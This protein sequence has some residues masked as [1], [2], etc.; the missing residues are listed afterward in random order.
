MKHLTKAISWILVCLLLIGTM[1]AALLPAMVLTGA[2][3]NP[4]PDKNKDGT[5][6][7][8]ATVK[9]GTV[10]DGHTLNG[11][12][13][14]SEPYEIASLVDWNYFAA[15]AA[16]AATKDTHFKLT[17][18]IYMNE[19]LGN[20]DEGNLPTV[21][22]D[23]AGPIN[24]VQPTRYTQVPS[25]AGV[26]DG[27]GYALYNPFM[28]AEKTTALFGT[29]TGTV[30]NL[31]VYGGYLVTTAGVSCSTFVCTLNGGTLRNC[32]VTT[33][34][35]VTGGGSGARFGGI[36]AVTDATSTISECV[37]TGTVVINSGSDGIAGGIVG[38]ANSGAL[39]IED[40]VN[41]GN[42]ISG[43]SRT[44][45]FVG[46]IVSGTVDVVNSVNHG[47]VTCSSTKQ[48]GVGGFVG[49]LYA[50]TLTATKCANYGNVKSTTYTEQT[51][52][53]V[54][55]IASGKQ[56]D[57]TACA[58]YGSITGSNASGL[59]GDYTKGTV[60]NCYGEGTFDNMK[61]GTTKKGSSSLLVS[62]FD[63]SKNTKIIKNSVGSGTA[64]LYDTMGGGVLTE[65]TDNTLYAPDAAEL[66][67]GTAVAL[68]NTGLDTPVWKQGATAP[69]IDGLPSL[70]S[71]FTVTFRWYDADGNLQTTEMLISKG[72]TATPPTLPTDRIEGHGYFA[73]WDTNAYLTV[74]EDMTVTA[75]Y[76]EKITVSFLP[77]EGDTP[78][79]T[80]EVIAGA[81]I[82]TLPTA[83]EKAGY[84][85][86]TWSP[87]PTTLTESGSVRAQYIKVWKVSFFQ[88]DGVTQIGETQ[89][90]DDGEDA[91]APDSA[92]V[93]TGGDDYIFS[94]WDVSYTAVHADTAVKA[95][96]MYAPLLTV[97]YY[98]SDRTTVLATEIV[99]FAKDAPMR[100]FSKPGY[101]LTGWE[102]TMTDIRDNT[103]LYAVWQDGALWDGSAVAQGL[104]GSGTE[105]DPYL[106]GTAAE[107]I[108]YIS[109]A[110]VYAAKGT[111]AKQTADI[112]FNGKTYNAPAPGTFAGVYDGDGHTITAMTRQNG[113]SGWSECA[114][115]GTVSG[116][117]KNLNMTDIRVIANGTGG[118]SICL[119]LTG[120][121]E[122]CHVTG[123]NVSAGFA[124]GLV[125]KID[126]GTVRNCSFDGTMQCYGGSANCRA[127]GIAASI[128]SGKIEN[129]TVAGE[130]STNTYNKNVAGAGTLGGIVANADTQD[131]ICEI[132]NCV[133]NAALNGVDA[134]SSG[135]T[136]VIGG[137]VGY[138]GTTNWVASLTLR[139]CRNNGVI[140]QLN[141][142][143]TG[144][145][146]GEANKTKNI[147]IEA[148]ENHGAINAVKK[149]GGLIGCI[150]AN[151]SGGE[152]I[153]IRGS[154]NAADITATGDA[155]GGLIGIAD[156]RLTPIRIIDS[157]NAGNVSGANKVGGIVG[158]SQV[159]KDRGQQ[160]T[161]TNSAVTGD[162][163]A[164]GAYAGLA[165]G[166]LM[167]RHTDSL[168]VIT[169]SVFVGKVTAA[170][171]AGALIGGV[172]RQE[173][174]A[175]VTAA[176][177]LD[178][179]F[180]KATV[181]V[182]AEAKAAVV[183]GT[184]VT[185]ELTTVN[186]TEQGS[187]F[188][189]TVTVGDADVATPG[190]YTAGDGT[191]V[192]LEL[193]ALGA[194]DLTDGT[195][196]AILN[197]YATAKSLGKWSQGGVAPVLTAF[198]EWPASI[199]NKPA[200][201]HP[202][203]GEAVDAE[204]EINRED[205]ARVEVL[206]YLASDIERTSPLPGAPTAVGR[207]VAVLR[208]YDAAGNELDAGNDFSVE[209]EITKAKTQIVPDLSGLNK[210]DDGTYSVEYNGQKIDLAAMLNDLAT[211]KRID[212]IVSITVTLGGNPADLKN[213]GVY[214]ITY[215]YG[216]N[217]N[218]E[219]AETVTVT[220][221]ITKK[222]IGY[223]ENRWTANGTDALPADAKLPYNGL[224]QI[225]R[226]LGA[227]E[228]IF[229]IDYVNNAATNAGGA[230][231]ASATVSLR[232]DLADYY[233]LTGTAPTYEWTWTV[234][235]ATVRVVILRT[236]GDM[237]TQVELADFEYSGSTVTYYVVF[238]DAN[239]NIVFTP[240]N[241]EIVVS[242]VGAVE[243]TFTWEGN[244][245]YEAAEETVA[246]KVTPKKL[247]E[248]GGSHADL[249]R[250]YDGN[251]STFSPDFGTAPEGTTWSAD[252][253]TLIE[254]KNGDTYE[255]VDEVLRGGEY[256]VTFT[257]V[258]NDGNY[259]ASFTVTFTI[260]RKTA[261]ITPPATG[262]TKVGEIFTITYDGKEYSFD[263]TTDSDGVLS[264]T[265]DC[266]GKTN[267]P[268][269]VGT[270]TVT[271]TVA[272]SDNYAEASATYTVRVDKMV[273]PT[274]P[275]GTELWDYAGAFTYDGQEKR[276]AV[277]AEFLAQYG[278][279]LDYRYEDNAKTAAGDYTARVIFSL[280]DTKNTKFADTDETEV[281]RQLTW[282]VNKLV[283]SVAGVELPDAYGIYT[284]SAVKTT[285][286]LPDDLKDKVNVRYEWTLNGQTYTGDA[287]HAGTYTVVAIL[288]LK[289]EVSTGFAGGE[290][291]Y[292]TEA[293]TVEITK[294]T[295]TIT[296]TGDKNFTLTY[297]GKTINI[298]SDMKLTGSDNTAFTP[299]DYLI[300]TMTKDGA[301]VNAIRDAGTYLITVS[302]KEN[303][304]VAAT[305]F[306]RTVTMER[307]T[308]VVDGKITV[309][310]DTTY[311]E[312]KA[313]DITLRVDVKGADGVAVAVDESR[314]PK[315]PNTP[316]THTVTYY[317]KGSDNYEPLDAFTVSVTVKQASAKDNRKG[318][319]G[320]IF[321][322]G[323][324]PDVKLEV[325]E[326]K[327]DQNVQDLMAGTTF[328]Q[329]ITHPAVK[330][331]YRY[332][333]T[334]KDGNAVEYSVFGDVSVVI[335]LPA[336]YRGYTKEE[337]FDEIS[338]IAVTYNKGIAHKMSV[339]KPGNVIYDAE[340]GTLTLRVT[341]PDVAYGYVAEASPVAAYVTIGVG[342]VALIAVI[343]LA[344][345][346]AIGVSRRTRPE[347]PDTPD[348]TDAGFG[349]GE[350]TGAAY[351]ADST[352]YAS[353]ETYASDTAADADTA[354]AEETYPDGE[355]PTE[356]T[357]AEESVAEDTA[358]ETPADETPAETP[359]EEM[360]VPDEMPIPD[361]D[362]PR[363]GE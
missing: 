322:E 53:I 144:G 176:I 133:N 355:T 261:T 10:P 247:G 226:L 155:V 75:L 209:F 265:Y 86:D 235:K 223:P 289:D 79:S 210:N 139:S 61:D 21:Y 137:I 277:K 296:V 314:L 239:D 306:T 278:I 60:R 220:L 180:V 216:G 231:T 184:I 117:I 51:A 164:S 3:A 181:K 273:I 280:A 38:R 98:D 305:S 354:T 130:L 362:T 126:G 108:C 147:T 65:A 272:A 301:A 271:V 97:T 202:Y 159:T 2:A 327:V 123:A 203:N 66:T 336:K 291:E 14:A 45:G 46:M 244:D 185:P 201:S 339:E 359:T 204:T 246:F 353:D 30:E 145:I 328:G 33:D 350:S 96:L 83:P 275:E 236:P 157:L 340:A 172:V 205:V 279:Y 240:E 290:T 92:L 337:L 15:T 254:R 206:Y 217:D 174:S 357:P 95:E 7:D 18:N 283:L 88:P 319:V 287:V 297:D 168:V 212:A 52:G 68:L 74:T 341:S 150:Y 146:L 100:Y 233:E 107:L 31:D 28:R 40:T 310:G 312:G 274:V 110:T 342:G 186:I 39:K 84:R 208:A 183:I 242:G 125:S 162:V 81:D 345:V 194:T 304:D 219:A 17:A 9:D 334:D 332:T 196:K 214:V 347:G 331:L 141:G 187:R 102:G 20:W 323:A 119:T 268:K 85:F 106:I 44:G 177:A 260:A 190:A 114:L 188:A 215:T 270:Y 121:L 43:V 344:V 316:G 35:Y 54:G 346:R 73:K 213:P 286:K 82:G 152:E 302:V 189:V 200:L 285:V 143:S 103:S 298:L 160:I 90:I 175:T 26:L 94:G 25:F 303:G 142:G 13:T 34:A 313:G 11:S 101:Y 333:F 324:D 192:T 228:S 55:K 222:Q 321:G 343:A 352:A 225:L 149:A 317:L 32:Y 129:C 16:K 135:K 161:V 221:T 325:V 318:D 87:D 120:K 112:S 63:K 64:Q 124:G 67:D 338:V 99:R 118:A 49:L 361:E 250:T 356:G 4:T 105:T 131:G 259:T 300:V 248:N 179:V 262:W 311:V 1:T 57:L 6:P 71:E 232:A 138:T 329:K 234:T 122:N 42:L 363:D 77:D 70:I 266:D 41:A 48:D 111:Y 360:P 93:T 23:K 8:G 255:K 113:P 211:G 27:D 153:V 207:Y 230:M 243:R 256:R 199:I 127:G 115:F 293:A 218:Y 264:I 330:Q 80:M 307:A 249:N 58:N 238:A 241:N 315:L 351:A 151:S 154:L 170:S 267:L 69:E 282:K 148:C 252:Y 76:G 132:I 165:A 91:V 281:T 193:T 62:W 167:T 12:G 19:Y 349:Y 197:A 294:N 116:T 224:E 292:R 191:A 348:G 178:S 358:E 258:T 158:D 128:T 245:N 56:V 24:G 299:A 257:G 29:V 166:S 173:K 326:N 5:L 59:T 288:T 263:A 237:T 47:N 50:G 195:V 182:A 295:A 229:T 156:R 227:D 251:K 89:I 253:E 308:Y 284:G 171:D 269:V 335:T 309:V 320:V 163:T 198:Y 136:S 276:V 22:D 140:T 109:N 104:G 37:Y 36:A 72:G 78:I 169:N 134:G